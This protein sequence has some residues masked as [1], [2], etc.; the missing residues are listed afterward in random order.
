MLKKK[1][2]QIKKLNL[3]FDKL[4]IGKK[5]SI[6]LHSNFAGIYQY[7]KFFS[8]K[9]YNYFLK[10]LLKRIGKSGTLLIPTYNYKFTNG[11][12]YDPKKSLSQVGSFSNYLIKHHSKNRTYEPV[13]NHLVFGKKRKLIFNCNT[14]ESFGNNS[15][16]S[17][18][19][20][21]NFKI[22]CFCCPPSKI[23]LIHYIEK[24]MNVKYRYDKYFLGNVKI[25]NKKRK[26]ALKYHVGKKQTNYKLK[27][28]KILN[29]I[30]NKNFIE[31]NY[32]RF[33]CYSVNA[34]YLVQVLTNKLKNKNNYLIK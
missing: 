18:I 33:N 16:F 31:T 20:K 32:G 34:K 6:V 2:K 25:K 29:L 15:V 22:L 17:I 9:L 13:F 23:T 3:L 1:F 11:I 10:F 4:K 12:V 26:I 21:Y 19:E 28:K 7:E 14:N 24:K 27:E 8:N 30:D 5:D